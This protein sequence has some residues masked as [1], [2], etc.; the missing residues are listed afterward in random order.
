ML[1]IGGTHLCGS[2]YNKDKRCEHL[3]YATEPDMKSGKKL[4]KQYYVYCTADGHCR[5]LGKAASWTGN[6]PTWCPKRKAMEGAK[7]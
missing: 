6:S 5:S 4:L 1:D 7:G 2:L 3:L